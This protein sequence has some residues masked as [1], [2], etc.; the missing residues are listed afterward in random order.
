MDPMKKNGGRTPFKDL[1]NTTSWGDQ[2][3]SN[4]VQHDIDSK[5]RKR[6]RD[7]ERW[8]TMSAEQKIE[9][10]KRHREARQRT[11]GQPLLP[12][13]SKDG[14]VEEEDEWLHRN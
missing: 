5:E 2:D 11:R 3:A 6:Q 14:D 8:A 9:K 12:E 4:S 1:T 13:I 10:N 7:K